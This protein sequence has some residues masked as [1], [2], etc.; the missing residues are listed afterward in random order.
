MRRHV[1]FICL[2]IASIAF[3]QALKG[4]LGLSLGDQWFDNISSMQGYVAGTIV[5]IW[6]WWPRHSKPAEGAA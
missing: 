3:E 1:L 5:A 2:Y 4:S 6:L